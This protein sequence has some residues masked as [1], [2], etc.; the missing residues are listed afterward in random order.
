[1]GKN[2]TLRIR[3][4]NV[5]SDTSK[6][7][8]NARSVDITPGSR[9]IKTPLRALSNGDLRAKAQVPSDIT[10]ASEIAGYHRQISGPESQKL[11]EGNLFPSTLTNELE[12]SSQKMQHSD[13]I[14]PFLQPTKTAFDNVLTSYDIKIKFLRKLFRIQQEAKMNILCVPWLNFTSTQYV[15]IIDLITSHESI[16]PIFYF[17]SKAKPENLKRIVDHLI[18]LIESERIH[19]L[20]ILYHPV[21]D[22]LTSYDV[23]WE[24]LNEKNVAILLADVERANPNLKNLSASHINEFILGDVFLQKVFSRGKPSP[25]KYDLYEKFKVFNKNNL[26]IEGIGNY[27]DESWKDIILEDFVDPEIKNTI[28]HY[29]EARDDPDK[30]SILKYISKVHEFTAS[31]NEFEKS[32][33]FIDKEESEVYIE[34]KQ[35]LKSALMTTKGSQKKLL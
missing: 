24:S 19:F 31:S 27:K 20:G 7:F 25:K 9:A 4:K 30:F 3:L 13:I 26:T 34:E 6:L 15:K 32:R 35:F 23:L 21:R 1:M 14:I 28:E 18:P 16:E 10:L 12:N 17:D 8:Y 22:A 29:K 11:L 33:V 2:L 5:D